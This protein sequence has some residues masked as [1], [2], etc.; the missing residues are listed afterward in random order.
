M[1][2][3]TALVVSV[4]MALASMV[5]PA[6][7]EASDNAGK[8]M[9]REGT[10]G[11]K[12]HGNDPGQ[13]Q[14]SPKNTAD[15]DCAGNRTA[16]PQATNKG[17]CGAGAADKPGG[18]GG[19]NSDKDWNNGCGNDTDREDDSN[20]WCGRKPRRTPPAVGGTSGG[21]TPVVGGTSGGTTPVVGGTSGGTTPVVTSGG[22]SSSVLGTFGVAG[23]P[24]RVLG[25][26]F[27]RGRVASAGGPKATQV[28]GTKLVRGAPLART[29]TSSTMLLLVAAVLLVVGGMAVRLGR[30]QSLLLG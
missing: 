10:E 4:V 18:S 3:I 19:F 23:G 14:G 15:P 30:R 12:L 1:K 2:R 21:T 25:V 6:F 11:Q 7:A 26:S 16:D 29:G 8:G 28:L 9:N 24:V 17:D 27:V 5:A 13:D 22:G 20:G